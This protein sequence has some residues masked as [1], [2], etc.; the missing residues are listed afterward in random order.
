MSASDAAK[1]LAQVDPPSAAGELS[2]VE[3]RRIEEALGRMSAELEQA[4][5]EL[6]LVKGVRARLEREVERLAQRLADAEASRSELGERVNER[7]RLLATVFASRSWRW[8][9]ALRRVIGRR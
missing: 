7:D 8:A 2:S 4:R 3:D 1:R 6:A 9:Q 5:F